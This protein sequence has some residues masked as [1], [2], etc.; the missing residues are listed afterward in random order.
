MPWEA[1]PENTIHH[2]QSV[3]TLVE[4]GDLWASRAQ[5]AVVMMRM[6]DAYVALFGHT[7]TAEADSQV[8]RAADVDQARIACRMP[9]PVSRVFLFDAL[10]QL[11]GCL[12]L[13]L[14]C[15]Q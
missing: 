7:Y 13:L 12:F 11:S 14:H 5:Q 6:K 1:T 10:H 8:Q 15:C 9:P 3:K 2:I 4:Q